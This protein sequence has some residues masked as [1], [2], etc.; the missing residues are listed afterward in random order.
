MEWNRG[1]GK[2]ETQR[3][4][5]VGSD[6]LWITSKLPGTDDDNWLSVDAGTIQFFDHGK[7]K[8]SLSTYAFFGTSNCTLS[9]PSGAA[10]AE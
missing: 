5:I 8:K 3:K 6:T 7:V 9:R 10:A 2:T 4:S 1:Q